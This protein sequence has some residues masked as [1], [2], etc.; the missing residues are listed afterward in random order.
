MYVAQIY[1]YRNSLW[2]EHLGELD[3]CFEEPESLECVRMVNQ[4]AKDNWNRF[5]AEN[6]TQLRGHL[7][8][9]PLKVEA[10]GA[11]SPL[12]EHENFP[13]TGGKVIGVHSLLLNDMLTT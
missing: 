10:D 1:G 8:K 2:A 7:L 4:I 12:P 11:I 3:A 5:T 13:D 6:F 9:Y